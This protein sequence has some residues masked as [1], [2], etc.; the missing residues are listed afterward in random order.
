MREMLLAQEYGSAS[1][2]QDAIAPH[3]DAGCASSASRDSRRIHLARDRVQQ[4]RT[5]R[6]TAPFL[7]GALGGTPTDRQADPPGILLRTRRARGIGEAHS[8]AN[9]RA[10]RHDRSHERL[11]P[12]SRSSVV[13]LVLHRSRTVEHCAVLMRTRGQSIATNDTL[14]ESYPTRRSRVTAS[15]TEYC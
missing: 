5:L 8:S 11:V 10:H 15:R 7:A 12:A 14:R 2:R 6:M 4:C 9:A 13:V 1:P 3:Q